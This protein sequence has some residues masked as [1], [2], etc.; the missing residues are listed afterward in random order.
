[1][2]IIK[3]V[4]V[5]RAR[6]S[7]GDFTYRTVRGRTIASQKRSTG[8]TGAITRG[9]KGNFRKPLFAMINIFM[10]Q[11]ASDIQVSFNKSKYG[12]QRNYFFT[13]NYTGL[14]AALQ[15]LALS[16]AATGVLPDVVTIEQAI[17]T[18]VEANPNVIYRVKLAGFAPVFMSS[19]W[20]SDD[21]PISG[22]SSDGLGSGT[23]ESRSGDAL[24]GGYIYNAPCALSLNFHAG[25]KIVREAGRTVITAAALS[26]GVTAA[27][28]KF[29]TK[30]GEE[31]SPAIVVTEVE[32]SAGLLKY[33]S[34]EIP[35]ASNILGVLVGTTY[36]RLSS[37]YVKTS[38][39]GSITG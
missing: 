4:G 30:T 12:S 21:N 9:Q 29:L 35:E 3:S 20:S 31:V 18:Y 10:L 13:T 19:P 23:I 25:A 2:A 34:P 5:G 15:Q 38:Y 24:E 28:I 16:A 14:S 1:M 36:I 27:A 7:V 11:H 32:S 22:G 6:K 17:N 33:S 37:A 39:N 8:A 26:S